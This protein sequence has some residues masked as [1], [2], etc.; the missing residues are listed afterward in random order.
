MHKVGKAIK[1]LLIERDMTVREL[2]EAAG[3]DHSKMYRRMNG[4]EFK[5]GE[6][7]RIARAL[8]I[9]VDEFAERIDV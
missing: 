2:E 7:V 6:G 1:G 8:G 3:I 9:S 4:K 5:L